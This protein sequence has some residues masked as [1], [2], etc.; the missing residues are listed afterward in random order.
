MRQKQKL[1]HFWTF[2]I[3]TTLRY[4]V[5]TNQMH[6]HDYILMSYPRTDHGMTDVPRN[7]AEISRTAAGTRVVAVV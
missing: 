2:R 5:Q 1:P 7:C 3:S 4:A 6:R